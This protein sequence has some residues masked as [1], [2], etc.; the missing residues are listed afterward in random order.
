MDLSLV[1]DV[2]L[3]P[4]PTV[5]NQKQPEI[6][7]YQFHL[8]TSTRD[9]QQNQQQFL[10]QSFV[11]TSSPSLNNPSSSI[12]H[13]FSLNDE[14]AYVEWSDGFNMLFGKSITHKETGIKRIQFLNSLF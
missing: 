7:Q 13:S 9:E 14:T 11:Q 1:T 5:K 6:G 8:S 3:I 2:I 12:L 4:P 10:H